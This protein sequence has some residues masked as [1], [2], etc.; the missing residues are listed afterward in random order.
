MVPVYNGAPY[1]RECLD[2]LLAQSWRDREILLMDDAST[3]GTPAIAASYGS[4]ITYVRQPVNRG[5]FRN[6]DDG[7]G[8]ATGRY[9]AVYHA[10]DVYDPEIVSQEVAFLEAHPEV[11]LVFSLIWLADRSAHVYGRLELPASLRGHDALSYAEVLTGILTYKNVFLPTPTAMARAELYQQVGRY[12]TEFGSAGDLDMW[13]RCARVTR[14]KVLE[15][16]LMR[17][18]HTTGSEGQSYQLAR[19][20]PENFFAVMDREIADYGAIQMTDEAGRAYEAHRAEDY[21]RI[22]VNTYIKGALSETRVAWG[23]VSVRALLGSGAIARPRLL[24]LWAM[25]GTAARLPHSGRFARALHW[26]YYGR[27]PWWRSAQG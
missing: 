6:V 22:C 16:H 9:I 27:L 26:R 19:T 11:G 4:A 5:Q 7:I 12:R 2:S 18:R 23:Q 3:D 14:I 10:D 25:L 15:R 24:L 20:T 21:L 17:Y 1:L 8:R 13:L